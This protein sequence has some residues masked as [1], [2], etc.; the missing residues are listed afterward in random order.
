M[1]NRAKQFPLSEQM[2]HIDAAARLIVERQPL[3]ALTGA[4]ISVESGIPDFRSPGGL[5]EKFDP[6]QYATREAFRRDPHKVWKMLFAVDRLLAAA[7]PNPAHRALVELADLGVLEAVV[8]QNIDGLHQAAGSP[9]VIEFHG[10]G[11]RLIC[12]SGCGPFAADT[13][14]AEMP[15]KSQPTPPLCPH[16][17]VV[18]IPDVVLFGD[19]IPEGALYASFHLARYAGVVLVVGTSATV[20]PAA[21]IPQL[22]AQFGAALV[23]LNLEPTALT[24]QA[25]FSLRGPASQTLPALTAAIRTHFADQQGWSKQSP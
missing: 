23:E 9:R 20:A 19:P 14:R 12:P 25:D 5:W 15:A 11:T 6:L 1:T 22:A 21:H 18:L 7:R 10:N 2:A 16:C 13:M 3:V 17:G 24:A 4:G 8:T